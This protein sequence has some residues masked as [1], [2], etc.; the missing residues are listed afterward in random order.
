MKTILAMAVGPTKDLPIR[1]KADLNGARPYIKGLIDGLAKLNRHI[2]T[3]YVIDYRE[4]DN[5]ETKAGAV[6]GFKPH[7]GE[8]EPGLIFGMSTTVVRAARG[9]T[10]GTPILGIVSDQKAES[11]SRSGHIT[12][13]SGRRSQTA[14]AC[15]ERFLATVPT[16]KSARVLH[17]PGYGPSERSLKLVRAIG[18]KRGVSVTPVT[19]KTRQDL[20]N[21]LPRLPKR[22]LNKPA[23][24]GVF[25]LPIDVCLSAAPYII[26]LVTAKNLPL[27]Y[28]VPD[29]V[30]PHRPSALGAFGVSQLKCGMLVAEHADQILWQGISPKNLKVKEAPDDAFEWVVSK[31]VAEA[32]RIKLPHLI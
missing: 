28:P 20:E 9:A 17:K 3:D 26:D 4:R 27:F 5:L 6:D 30:K 16:L 15:F 24:L 31:E 19:V 21:K 12:G 14:G 29:W 2:G 25:V 1:S 32:L 10:Q 22:D 18:K 8:E 13:V 7:P 11:F 23:E